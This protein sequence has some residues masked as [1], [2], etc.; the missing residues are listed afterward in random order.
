[1]LPLPKGEAPLTEPTYDPFLPDVQRDP[2]PHYAELRR[3]AP[4]FPVRNAYLRLPFVAS[5]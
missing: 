4:V 3:V 5:K 1:M 2:Y